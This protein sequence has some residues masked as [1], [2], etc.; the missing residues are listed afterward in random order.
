MNLSNPTKYGIGVEATPPIEQEV[1]NR[2]STLVYRP[3]HLRV[4]TRKRKIW[5]D[6]DNS[7]HVP[8]FLPIIEELEKQGIELILTARNMYQVCELLQFFGLP[9]NVI[10]GHYGKNKLLK[11][12]CNCQR[13]A[14]LAPLVA[15]R[16]PNLA[17][18][19]GSRAQVLVSKMLGIP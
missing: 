5:I 19:H 1:Q 10:G 9:C 16:R 11:I 13:A 2:Q 18:S 15:R 17:L 8:F 14:Q 12:L 3:E 4:V 6:I 7:P